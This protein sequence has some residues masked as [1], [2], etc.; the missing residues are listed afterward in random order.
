MGRQSGRKIDRKNVTV[1]FL[2]YLTDHAAR[3]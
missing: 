3:V 1:M 2:F